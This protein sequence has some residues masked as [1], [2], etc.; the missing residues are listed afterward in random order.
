[1][2]KMCEFKKCNLFYTFDVWSLQAE[3]MEV[4]EANL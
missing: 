1:M 2:L 3:M 4:Y